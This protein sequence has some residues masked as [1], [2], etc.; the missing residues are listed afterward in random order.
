MKRYVIQV[1]EKADRDLDR[2]VNY[3]LHAKKNRQAAKNLLSDYRKT[4][5]RLS[6]VAGSLKIPESEALRSRNLKRLNFGKHDYFLLFR[7]DGE[8]A[9]VTN[10]FHAAEDFELKL[11]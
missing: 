10:I 9:I 3:L 1:T 2:C 4:L 6:N 8:K 7:I 11:S 5:D